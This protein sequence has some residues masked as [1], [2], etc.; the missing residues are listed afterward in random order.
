MASVPNVDREISAIS[1]KAFGGR[2]SLLW[3]A[4]EGTL[5]RSISKPARR[6]VGTSASLSGEPARAILSTCD[7]R[8]RNSA[9]LCRADGRA[10]RHSTQGERSGKGDDGVFYRRSRHVHCPFCLV[11]RP[12]RLLPSSIH[13][14]CQVRKS[15]ILVPYGCARLGDAAPRFGV[16][17]QLEDIAAACP[18]TEILI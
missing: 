11:G 12:T 3:V 18:R 16:S 9:G 2:P 5:V 4:C 1:A 7:L 8:G 15:A 14:A 10:D 13:E 6:S 17:S